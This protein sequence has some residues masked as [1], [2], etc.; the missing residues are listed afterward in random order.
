[1]KTSILKNKDLERL[2]SGRMP[3]IGLTVH[4]WN[5]VYASSSLV[6]QTILLRYGPPSYKVAPYADEWET[7]KLYSNIIT[8]VKIIIT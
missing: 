3:V 5:V 6:V 2:L 7:N 4:A 1:M 8:A